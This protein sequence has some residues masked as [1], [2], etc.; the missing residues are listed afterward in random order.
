MGKRKL[1]RI[2]IIFILFSLIS[3]KIVN[4]HLKTPIFGHEKPARL[5]I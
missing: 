3:V 4:G 1:A 2:L 5:A